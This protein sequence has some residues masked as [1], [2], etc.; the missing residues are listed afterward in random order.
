MTRAAGLAAFVILAAPVLGAAPAAAAPK[1]PTISW[2]GGEFET[3]NSKMA[4]AAISDCVTALTEA[5]DKRLNTAYRALMAA[6]NPAQKERLRTAQRAWIQF[7]DANC[8][9]YGSVEGTIANIEFA[10]CRRVLTAQRTIELEL[11]NTP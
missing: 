6:Q 8:T 4:T 11:A 1:P 5:W 9:F 3:C 2:Y 7:R 10:E